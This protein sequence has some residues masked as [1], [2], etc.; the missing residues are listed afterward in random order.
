MRLTGMTRIA[1]SLLA[2]L[3]SAYALGPEDPT[4]DPL[5][6]SHV[7]SRLGKFP[8]WPFVEAVDAKGIEACKDKAGLERNRC[9]AGYTWRVPYSTV[10]GTREVARDLRR[11]WQ[12]FE[13]RYY[14]RVITQ[15]NNPLFYI[16]F[17]WLGLKGGDLNPPLPEARPSVETAAIP[18]YPKDEGFRDHLQRILGTRVPPSVGSHSLD[19]YYPLPQVPTGEFCDGL[20]LDLTIMYIPGFCINVMGFEW[21][22]PGYHEDQPFWFNEGAAQDR[23]NRAI[24]H[25]IKNYYADYLKNTALI[26]SKPRPENPSQLADQLRGQNPQPLSAYLPLP[27]TT[28]HL[29]G[30]AVIAP[31]VGDVKRLD[32]M[33]QDTLNAV[34]EAWSAVDRG[35][36]AFPGEIQPLV[37]GY[38]AQSFL[39][40]AHLPGLAPVA[41]GIR[42]ALGSFGNLDQRALEANRTLLGIADL[43]TRL[44]DHRGYLA[45]EQR[46]GAP[47][48]FPFEE[49]KRWFPLGNILLQERLGYVSTFQVY[50]R[51]DATILP[52]PKDAMG[53]F[54]LLQRVIVYWWIPVKFH[55]SFLPT[56]PFL[57]I[58]AS[59]EPPKP[60]PV[61]PYVLPF[62][63]ERVYYTWENV[64]LGYPIPRVKGTPVLTHAGLYGALLNLNL[65]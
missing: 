2:L 55:I 37:M 59:L 24:D 30:G 53:A 1:L 13:D 11:E 29:Q 26:A 39:S 40:L 28:N 47:G 4:Y 38:Y 57:N 48:A 34:R 22:T 20:G 62:M 35:K 60:K 61:P 15:L 43:T 41:Q 9:L 36:E 10:Q 33:A 6:F 46:T 14:W 21:C 8:A 18:P 23:V 45:K 19:V 31:V 27:W 58:S 65:R 51:I 7:E 63:G 64:P 54:G 49:I 17:C 25:A 12:R 56:P 3:G 52:T 42:S 32:E 16:P 50:N 5:R 44:Q